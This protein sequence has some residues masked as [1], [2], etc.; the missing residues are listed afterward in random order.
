MFAEKELWKSHVIVIVAAA[1]AAAFSA[2]IVVAVLT[3]VFVFVSFTVGLESEFPVADDADPLLAASSRLVSSEMIPSIPISV[4][5]SEH[6]SSW[7][8][9]SFL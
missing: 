4:L 1:L 5:L 3:I 7:I 2:A 9:V 6:S 8:N